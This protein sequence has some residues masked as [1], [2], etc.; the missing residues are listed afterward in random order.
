V[1]NKNLPGGE[2]ISMTVVCTVVLS[3][4]GHG[5]S[6]NPLIAA[7]GARLGRSAPQA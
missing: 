3:I 5:I 2:T 7:L 6:A 1:L 4:L